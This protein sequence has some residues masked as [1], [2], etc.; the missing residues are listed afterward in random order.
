MRH[1]RLAYPDTS[2]DIISGGLMLGERVGTI[3]KVAPYVKTAYKDV[4]ER[5]GVKFGDSFVN[6]SLRDGTMRLDSMPP[7]IAMAIFREKFPN[8]AL[9]YSEVLHKMIYVDGHSSDDWEELTNCAVAL[10]YDREEFEGKLNDEKYENLAKQDFMYARQL[11]VSGYPAL[12]IEHQGQLYL[13]A[14]GFTNKEVLLE[15]IERLLN[16]K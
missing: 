9:T 8:T 11:E 15:R 1:L 3:D 6:G 5:T 16:T 13:M 10:G 12:I 14:K 7:A 4:E 2:I